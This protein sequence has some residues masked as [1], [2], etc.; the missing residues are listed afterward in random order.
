MRLACAWLA[1]PTPRPTPK[2]RLPS[3]HLIHPNLY[4]S[5][6]VHKR[7]FQCVGGKCQ[8]PFRATGNDPSLLACEEACRCGGY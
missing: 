8:R 4:A 3:Q 5:T 2:S 6:K 7:H 1:R